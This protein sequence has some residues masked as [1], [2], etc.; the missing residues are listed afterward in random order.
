ML[1][2]SVC[3]IVKNE[4]KRLPVCLDSLRPYGFEIVIVDTGSADKTKEVAARYTDKLFD[5]AWCGDFSTARN[6]SLRMASNPFIFMLDADEWVVSLDVEEL[7]YFRKRLS[8]QVGVVTRQNFIGGQIGNTDPT[9]RFFSRK[10][11]H[12][13]GRIHEQLRPLRGNDF[14]C[15]LTKTII[16]HSGYDMTDAERAEKA[17][18]NEEKAVKAAD[19]RRRAAVERAESEEYRRI[20]PLTE[21][22]KAKNK[23]GYR[24]FLKEMCGLDLDK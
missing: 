1:P 17:K 5:F 14:P 24:T 22:E 16:G 10:H 9:E 20:H 3:M 8:A 11:Y 2:I 4:E 7:Q 23:A 13:E 21:D 18:R 12:Y 15:L 6:Y 19:E